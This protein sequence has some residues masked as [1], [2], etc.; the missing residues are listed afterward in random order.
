MLLWNVWGQIAAA[1]ARIVDADAGH[2][3]DLKGALLEV[4]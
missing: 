4:R 1:R 3:A 2:A